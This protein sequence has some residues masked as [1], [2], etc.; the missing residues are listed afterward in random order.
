MSNGVAWV[1]SPLISAASYAQ[2]VGVT[3]SELMVA[4]GNVTIGAQSFSPRATT[5]QAPDVI[6][7]AGASIDVSGGWRTFQAGLVQTSEL[8]DTSGQVVNVGYANPDD[9]YVAV[10]SG[11]TS[12]QP[13]WGC[14][15]DLCRSGA[16]WRAHGGRLHRRYADAG[17]LTIK[18]SV[19]AL[20]GQ[21]FAGAFAGPQQIL[22]AQP[23]T[24]SGTIYGDL[25]KLQGAPSQ[26]PA[27]GYLDIQA[28]GADINHIE[29]GGGDI[30]IVGSA[31][32]SPVP[33]GFAYG[34]S[35]SFDPNNGNL[36]VPP[37][38]ASS[39][40][41]TDRLDVIS[42]NADALST[43]GLSQLT[44]QTS[45]KV[46]LSQSATVDLA[47]GGVFVATAGRGLTVDGNIVAPSGSINL[48]TADFIENGG[49]GGFGPAAPGRRGAGLLRHHHQRPVERGGPL[50]QRLRRRPGPDRGLS[51]PER[52]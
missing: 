18:A 8:V 12:A 44:V 28:L 46:D 11:F 47:A 21:V 37:R 9:T 26:L 7:M 25:R 40:L 29:T 6:I 38:P 32:Y 48:T 50:G 4:G 22:D 1:G 49:L 23:G 45:G 10:Y 41:P 27:G 15:P 13:R 34:Q 42:L 20:D 2:Q 51:L 16:Q 17:T 24:A 5:S 31:D 19:A 52:R 3:A 39:V 35:I 33:T 43:M 14:Q 30:A 36:I